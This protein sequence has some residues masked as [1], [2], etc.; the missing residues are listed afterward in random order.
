[1]RV[2]PPEHG[3]KG[4]RS[5]LP[6]KHFHTI[7]YKSTLFLGGTCSTDTYSLGIR[8]L[9]HLSTVIRA[10]HC[11]NCLHRN[12]PKVLKSMSLLQRERR[13]VQVWIKAERALPNAVHKD[14]TRP[15][16]H[17]HTIKYKSTLFQGGTCSTYTYSP[18]IQVLINLSTVIRANH[19]LDCLHRN[20]LKVLKSMSLLQRE[21]RSVQVWIKVERT[22]TIPI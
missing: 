6:H 21:R 7:K 20:R 11:L 17:F 13:S 4:F 15:H 12:R 2:G 16:K 9:I 14:V 8:M 22:K 3:P 19:C 1:M 5:P 10:N 18:D